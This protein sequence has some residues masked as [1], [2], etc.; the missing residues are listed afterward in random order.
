MRQWLA[1]LLSPGM[2]GYRL[3]LY[4]P[5][6]L[7]LKAYAISTGQLQPYYGSF[8]V[9]INLIIYVYKTFRLP[10]LFDQMSGLLLPHIARLIQR[11]RILLPDDTSILVNQSRY[12]C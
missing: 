10:L 6:P 3:S 12:R 2:S 7:N 9:L 5:R 11:D 1:N 8:I 4:V